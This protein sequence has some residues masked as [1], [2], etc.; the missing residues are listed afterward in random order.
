MEFRIA[1][2]FTGSLERLPAQQQKAVKTTAFDLQL[3]PAAPGLKFHRVERS[4]DPHFWTVRVNDDIRVVVHKTASSFL[5]CYVDHHDDA[6]GWA[7]RRKIEAHPTTGAA[8]LV[9]IVERVVEELPAPVAAAAALQPVAWERG[10]AL[11]GRLSDED[12]LSYGVPPEWVATVRGVDE[13]GL[14]DLAGHIPQEAMEA[15]L[16]VAVGGK[17]AQ[18][19]VASAAA[20]PFAHPDAQRRFRTVSNVEE[21]RQ[22]L[23]YPW[24]KWTVFLHP[25]QREVVD[26]R[27]GGPARVTGSA[28]TGKTVVAL[29]RAVH[30]ARQSPDA[31]VLLATFSKNLSH[32]L[33][34]KLSRLLDSGDEA[35]GRITVGYVDGIAHQLYERVFGVKPNM[36]SSSQV[37]AALKAAAKELGETRFSQRFLVNEWRFV[38]PRRTSSALAGGRPHRTGPTQRPSGAGRSRSGL[39][40]S[41]RP[42]RVLCPDVKL[43]PR[44]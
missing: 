21:L 2:T 4:K 8:Q 31:R 7:E 29:H 26:R 39:R 35:A 23:E 41:P 43:L 12:L 34:L 20:D 11:F 32:A 15:L 10:P 6:Y 24:E 18:P 14:F 37:E 36:A 33:K 5:L 44:N 25:A 9:E 13:E 19:A 3:N 22:S 1:D 42:L 27:Y 40:S 16:E 17:P 30:L 38:V 28:G